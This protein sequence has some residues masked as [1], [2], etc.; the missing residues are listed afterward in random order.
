[1]TAANGGSVQAYNVQLAVSD[2]HVIIAC[3]AH[4]SASDQGSFEPMLTAAVHAAQILT[5][6]TG[7]PIVTTMLPVGYGRDRGGAGR[8]RVSQRTQ[9]D[10]GRSATTDRHRQAP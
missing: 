1:M 3:Q 7:T 10:R 6:T 8:R 2:D 4:Q 5:A 9:P